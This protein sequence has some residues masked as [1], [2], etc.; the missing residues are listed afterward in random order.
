MAVFLGKWGN[1][2]DVV[3]SLTPLPKGVPLHRR[4]CG[5]YNTWQGCYGYDACVARYKQRTRG[6]RLHDLVWLDAE[7]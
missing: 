4:G 2:S 3:P 5:L 6:S 1:I 7:E